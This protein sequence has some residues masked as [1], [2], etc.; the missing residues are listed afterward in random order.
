MNIWKLSPHNSQT[1]NGIGTDFTHLRYAIIWLTRSKCQNIREITEQMNTKQGI[2]ANLWWTQA[3]AD[4]HI[5][6]LRY[7]VLQKWRGF[8]LRFHDVQEWSYILAEKGAYWLC[9]KFS[10]N[11]F[12]HTFVSLHRKINY[13]ALM[14]LDEILKVYSTEAVSYTPHTFTLPPLLSITDEHKC[15]T[16]SVVSLTYNSH[17]NFQSPKHFHMHVQNYYY[18]SCLISVLWC[19]EFK[20]GYEEQHG[21]TFL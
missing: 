14:T 17:C 3:G 16:K 15:T 13:I 1:R 12:S 19:T 20:C 21:L 8:S 4:I 5:I 11:C 6:Q 9:A 7:W 2:Q 10:E 18:S